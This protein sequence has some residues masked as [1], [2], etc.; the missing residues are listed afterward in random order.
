MIQTLENEFWKLE[1]ASNVGASIKSLSAK[2]GSSQQN[3]MRVTPDEALEKASVSG[4]SS[5]ALA[6]FSNRIRDAKFVFENREYQLRANN[7]GGTS[8]GDVRNHPWQVTRD[9][10]LLECSIDS[11]DFADFN[12]PFP[13]RMEII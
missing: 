2:Q 7:T 4:F 8:H 13:M 11:R 10:H 9:D 5:F 6:P 3:L 12:F 1:V